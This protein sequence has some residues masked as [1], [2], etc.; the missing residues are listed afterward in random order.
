M[1]VPRKSSLSP[2]RQEL[3]DRMCRIRFGR[4]K[5]LEVRDGEPVIGADSKVFADRTFGRDER[6]AESPA[7]NDFSLK[8]QHIE[9]FEAFDRIGS[10]RIE[11]L[12]VTH[13]LPFR[14]R[15]EDPAGR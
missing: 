11:F 4:I 14:I 5:A 12:D 13:G 9:L 3:V 2:A 6:G 8:R 15:V 10:G 7:G 1:N